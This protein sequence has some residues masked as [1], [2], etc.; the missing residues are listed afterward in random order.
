MTTTKFQQEWTEITVRWG[1][2]VQT[3]FVVK[4]AKGEV[5][6]SVLLRDVGAPQGMLLVTDFSLISPYADELVNL[7][8]ARASANPPEWLIRTMTRL[9][10]RC[11]QIGDGRGAKAR[12]RGIVNPAANKAMQTD[13]ASR[14]R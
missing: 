10:W 2:R 7:G 8:Y 4:L 3:P 11:F 13:A 6:V 12:L 9:S 1:I 5:T 14:R